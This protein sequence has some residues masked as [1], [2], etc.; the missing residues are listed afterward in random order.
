[1]VP[2]VRPGCLRD[3]S[4]CTLWSVFWIPVTVPVATVLEMPWSVNDWTTACWDFLFASPGAATLYRPD[5]SS[6]TNPF[7]G[8]AVGV[9][10]LGTASLSMG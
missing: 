2:I 6:F 1:M 9:A 10:S 8:T 7:E 3:I 5:G 4:L